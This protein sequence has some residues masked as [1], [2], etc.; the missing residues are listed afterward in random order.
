MIEVRDLHK[1]FKKNHVLKG[2]NLKL[3]SQGIYALLGPNGS[4]KTTL[5]KTVLGMVVS[6]E[7]EIFIDGENIR[8]G[9]TYRQR[10]NYM[11]QIANFP[12][13]IKVR[14][15][16]KMIIDIRAQEAN[17]EDLIQRF[18]LE[19][20]LDHKLSNLSGGSAQKVNLV[21]TFMFD[22]PYYILDEPTTG[23][24]PTALIHFKTLLDQEKKKG[25]TILITTHI[26]PFVE[27]VADE[28]IYI[29]EGVIGFKGSIPE[30]LSQYK[31]KDVE[32]AIAHMANSMTDA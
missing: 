20:Y 16:I 21:L 4:G 9:Y 12:A 28:I 10:L 6:K 1:S 17:Y 5:I 23:L 27:E 15:L 31:S 11:P 2:V 13:N 29:L 14:E 19:A 7:G 8:K 25:K 24:D 32:H 3:D 30:L 26:M 22:N 18:G